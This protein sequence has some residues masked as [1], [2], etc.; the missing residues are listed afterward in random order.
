MAKRL[1]EKGLE[2]LTAQRRAYVTWDAVTTGL[3][4]KTT[5]RGKKVWLVQL[6]FPGR[7]AQSKRSLGYYP[8]ISLVVAREQAEK[9]Y[10]LVKGGV[11][12]RE[13][14]AREQ[15]AREADR[16]AEAIKQENTFGPFA[17]KYIGLRTNRRAKTDGQ[18]IRLLLIPA[19]RDWPIHD[20]TPRDVRALIDKIDKRARAISSQGRLGPC[21]SDFPTRGPR[22]AYPR[23]AVRQLGQKTVVQGRIVCGPAARSGRRGTRGILARDRSPQPNQHGPVLS[24]RQVPSVAAANRRPIT[25]TGQRAARSAPFGLGGYPP[26]DLPWPAATAGPTVDPAAQPEPAK[27]S[28]NVIFAGQILSQRARVADMDR[29]RMTNAQT[30]LHKA[31]S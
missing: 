3:G 20:I 31:A 9:W 16:L 17:E 7:A 8:A 30:R 22:A 26:P 28:N 29:R 6:K 14:E 18:E 19:W 25:R 21:R 23:L 15:K 11:D 5:P 24:D 10:A 12:P 1:T 27:P 2:A 13:E 4:L